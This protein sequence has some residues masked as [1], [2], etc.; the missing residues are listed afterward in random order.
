M[1][2][3]GK[4]SGIASIK[5]HPSAD[6]AVLVL[7]HRIPETRAWNGN[8][9][10]AYAVLPSVQ[11]SPLETEVLAYGWYVS[12]AMIS[13]YPPAITNT[14]TT[15]GQTSQ[16]TN[17]QP[18]QLMKVK[19][20][21]STSSACEGFRVRQNLPI[22]SSYQNFCTIPDKFGKGTCVGD[23]GGPVVSSHDSTLVGIIS[24]VA[25]CGSTTIPTFVVRVGDPAILR[26]IEEVKRQYP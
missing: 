17:S 26:F 25:P 8:G 4:V 11:R 22:A 24:G 20:S 9:K 7:R 19:M 2:H 12:T 18:Q 21:V 23:A 15:R 6:I 10:I 16:V 13:F 3:K 1:L 14:F 5:L